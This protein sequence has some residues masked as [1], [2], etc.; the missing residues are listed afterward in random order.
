MEGPVF[1]LVTF[2]ARGFFPGRSVLF[3][4]DLPCQRLISRKVLRF[5]RGPSMPGADFMEG[6]A[7]FVGTFHA[8]GRFQGRSEVLSNLIFR[9]GRYPYD[10]LLRA[11]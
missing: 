5:C 1:L 7:F 10:L 11:A 3:Q 4:G 8:R 9:D 2:H 6:P